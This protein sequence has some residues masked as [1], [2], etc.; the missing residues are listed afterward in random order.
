MNKNFFLV[1]AASCFTMFSCNKSEPKKEEQN[2]PETEVVEEVSAKETSVLGMPIFDA[3][4]VEDLVSKKENDTLYVTN[5][6]ATWC[7]P[8]VREMPHFAEQMDALK[9]KPV[10]FTFVSVDNPTDWATVVNSFATEYKIRENVALL[11]ATSLSSD[12]FSKNFN[13]WDG[14]SIPFTIFTK[15]DKREEILGTMSKEDLEAKINSFK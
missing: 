13:S 1:V 15:K 8:C 10:K 12:F 9:D 5:F 3:K 4:N 6:F 7:G 11:D 2:E 14:G